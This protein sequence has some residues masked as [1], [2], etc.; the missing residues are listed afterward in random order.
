[1]TGVTA[2]IGSGSREAVSKARR[3]APHTRGHSEALRAGGQGGA[4]LLQ[5][6]CYHQKSYN[7]EQSMR[8]TIIKP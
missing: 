6:W 5:R 2:H 8:L 1:M 3:R 7:Q 4:F